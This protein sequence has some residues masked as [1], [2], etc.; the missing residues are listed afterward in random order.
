MWPEA[1]NAIFL[2]STTDCHRSCTHHPGKH[3]KSW[4]TT[5]LMRENTWK[6]DALPFATLRRLSLIIH[7]GKQPNIPS[8]IYNIKPHKFIIVWPS[9]RQMWILHSRHLTKAQNEE[10]SCDLTAQLSDLQQRALLCIPPLISMQ[11]SCW[12][13]PR[14]DFPDYPATDTIFTSK[15]NTDLKKADIFPRDFLYW[16]LEKYCPLKLKKNPKPCNKNRL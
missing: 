6:K 14:K 4:V 12:N 15:G 3:P 7:R 8:Q 1:G 5:K 9:Q 10:G 2:L 13:L 11:D 16:L